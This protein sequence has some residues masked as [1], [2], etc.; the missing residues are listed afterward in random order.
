MLPH[1][2]DSVK[3]LSQRVNRTDHQLSHPDPP[4]AR[5]RWHVRPLSS[6]PVLRA[7]APP[8]DPARARIVLGLIGAR[9]SS[10][11]PH[12][13][14]PPILPAPKLS[15]GRVAARFAFH[16]GTSHIEVKISNS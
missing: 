8:D 9:G 5:L 2:M 12:P 11:V 10:I 15:H 3:Q 16:G 14:L 13:Y 1:V 4:R 6:Y 7:G